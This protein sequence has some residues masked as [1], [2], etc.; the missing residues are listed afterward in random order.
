MKLKLIKG[1]SYCGRN[2][3]ATIDKPIYDTNDD[4][5][6]AALVD[7]GYFIVVENQSDGVT[8]EKKETTIEDKKSFDKA[9]IVKMTKGKSLQTFS[10]EQLD[11]YAA[12]NNIDFTGLS[13]KADKL[14]KI[15][16]ILAD[17]GNIVN[18]GN[19]VPL[20]SALPNIETGT[21]SCSLD[22]GGDG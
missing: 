6:A 8:D 5:L 16:E 12:A 13:K 21:V 10:L 19:F 1:R 4:A 15:Q 3:K 22:F 2:V 20:H 18:K 7:S 11:E 17:D 14:A 9:L